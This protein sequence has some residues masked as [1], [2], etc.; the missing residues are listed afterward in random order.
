MWLFVSDLSV[1]LLSDSSVFLP[2]NYFRRS[3]SSYRE[4]LRYFPFYFFNLSHS[5]IS[6][7]TES[8]DPLSATS[9]IVAILQV[10]EKVLTSCYRYV[11]NVQS[12]SSDLDRIVRQ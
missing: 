11:G 3:S 2:F 4:S 7:I 6:T 5:S 1:P 10:S 8:M 12:A 9:S